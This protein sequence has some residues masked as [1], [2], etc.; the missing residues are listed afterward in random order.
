LSQTLEKAL[1]I[2][3]FLENDSRAM[4]YGEFCSGVVSNEKNVLFVNLDYG[5]G[6]GILVDG[7]LYYG[8]SGFSGEFG[9]MP[10]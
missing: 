8:K 6:L 1:G 2:R 7:K 10:F 5:T 9:H 4:A 3:T